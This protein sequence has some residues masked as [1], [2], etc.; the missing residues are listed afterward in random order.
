MGLNDNSFPLILILD[1]HC[2]TNIVFFLVFGFLHGVGGDFTDDVSGNAVSPIF[3][4]H[5]SWLVKMGP[6]AVSETSSVNSPRTPCKNPKTKK[7]KN[8]ISL[9]SVGYRVKYCLKVVFSPV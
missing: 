9:Q 5:D 6:T 7:Q 1:F 3:I 8:S 4:G 2:G